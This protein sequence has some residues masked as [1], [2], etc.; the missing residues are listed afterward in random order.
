[1]DEIKVAKFFTILADEVGDVSGKEQLAL[2]IR[3]V[4]E[5]GIV[6]EEFLKFIL[7]EEGVSGVKLTEYIIF[8]LNEFGL[9]IQIVEVK[10][11]MLLF[12]CLGNI[13]VLYV[14]IG[15]V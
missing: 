14:Y 8:S 4:D 5:G 12:V 6:R 15:E 7:C 9:D 2:V 3:F 13:W 10:D 1:M 11:M